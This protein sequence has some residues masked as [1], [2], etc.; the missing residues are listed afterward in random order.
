MHQLTVE[1]VRFLAYVVVG[2]VVERGFAGGD[3]LA[4]ESVV[5]DVLCRPQEGVYGVFE[6]YGVVVSTSSATGT[7]RRTPISYM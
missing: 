1:P 5:Y 3:V 7:V 4:F 2:F 6:E